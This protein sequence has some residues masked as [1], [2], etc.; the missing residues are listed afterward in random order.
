V[1]EIAVTGFQ[2]LVP[3]ARTPGGVFCA[4]PPACLPASLALALALTATVIGIPHPQH[5]NSL[6]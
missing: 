1:S 2:D 6:K 3:R 5:T 4:W